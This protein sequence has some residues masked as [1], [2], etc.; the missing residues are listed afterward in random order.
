MAAFDLYFVPGVSASVDAEDAD[1]GLAAPYY[2]GTLEA[3]WMNVG[4]NSR[5]TAVD[6]SVIGWNTSALSASSRRFDFSSF[7]AVVGGATL[8]THADNWATVTGFSILFDGTIVVSSLDLTACIIYAGLRSQSSGGIFT[9]I[10]GGGFPQFVDNDTII[11]NGGLGAGTY[12]FSGEI[13]PTDALG[14][15]SAANALVL[16]RSATF[17]A[18][19]LFYNDTATTFEARLDRFRLRVAGTIGGPRPQYQQSVLPDGRIVAARARI[20]NRAQQ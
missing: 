12:P 11:N 17:M 13:A 19:G 1:L 4:T 7:T 6:A 8:K 2:D 5:L 15:L 14:G 18:R 9:P 20:R 16:F 3:D 10:T